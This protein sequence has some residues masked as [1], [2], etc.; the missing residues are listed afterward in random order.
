NEIAQTEGAFGGVLANT[1]MH[2]GPLMVDAD[3]MSKSLGN[4]RTIREAV[5]VPGSLSDEAPAYQ[6]NPREAEML[7]FFIVRNHYRSVQNYTP[8]N[9][10]DA[11]HALDRLYQT[12]HNV[13]AGGDAAIDWSHPSAQAFRAAMD[14]DFNTSGAVAVLFE[15]A[16]EANRDGSGQA[17]TL[18]RSLGGVL[19]LLQ[20]DPARYL[21][22]PS[23]YLGADAAGHDLTPEAIHA[24]ID[25][26]AAAKTAR[27]FAQADRI[28]QQLR[29]AG[30]ELEDKA[31]G[32]TQWRRV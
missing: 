24:L 19:G 6:A 26:R 15:L 29:E 18:L 3:K 16:S 1:W 17:A 20:A 11:Q 27:D 32:A 10:R 22:S 31:G 2:C 23:R 28:R 21:Q 5:A 9:L 12:L 14:D 4:F 13:P 8:D 25:E 30:V 7:R